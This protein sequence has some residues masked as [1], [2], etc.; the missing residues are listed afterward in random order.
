MHIDE[1]KNIEGTEY[2]NCELTEQSFCELDLCAST[3]DDSQ[4]FYPP[5]D[6]RVYTSGIDDIDGGDTFAEY[7]EYFWETY[8]HEIYDEINF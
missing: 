3:A 6:P 7:A 1:I 8:G 2:D 4:S 5:E